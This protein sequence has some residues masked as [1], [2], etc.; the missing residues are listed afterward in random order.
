[1]RI[2]FAGVF[3]LS[4]SLF[5]SLSSSLIHAQFAGKNAKILRELELVPPIVPE[6]PALP[7]PRANAAASVGGDEINCRDRTTGR[8]YKSVKGK[9]L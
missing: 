6:F 3:L 1:M 4:L 9:C 2:K 7:T 8:E 5:L